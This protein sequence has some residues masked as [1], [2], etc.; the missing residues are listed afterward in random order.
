MPP[1]V[2]LVIIG[3]ESA[4]RR[5]AQ[6]HAQTARPARLINTYGPTEATV[7]A[8]LC[9][10]RPR[11]SHDLVTRSEVPIG[12]PLG[13]A[14][15]YILDGS[16]NPLPI[17]VPGELL[18]RRCRVARGYLN[19][20]ELTAE[21]FVPDPFSDAPEA[22]LYRAVTLCATAPTGTSSFWGAW[23]SRSRSGASAS[24]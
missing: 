13:N 1:S 9:E 2:R 10:L 4:G 15:I 16:L 17:G 22:R 12:R 14:I 11:A 3:G 8:T 24:S 5:V 6:W 18:H 21:R 19:R 20:P 23:M 7:V